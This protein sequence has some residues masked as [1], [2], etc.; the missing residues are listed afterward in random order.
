MSRPNIIVFFTDQQRFDSTG[1]HG[2]PMGLTP[3]FDRLASEGTFVRNSFTCQPVCG[4]ARACFQTGMY[5]TRTGVY[6]NDTIPRTDVR[7]LGH[8]FNDAGYDTAYIGKWHLGPNHTDK[9]PGVVEPQFRGGYKRW[10]ASNLLEFTSDAYQ[11]TL[12]DNDGQPVDLPG[13]RVDALADAAIRYVHERRDQEDPFFLFL[14]FLEPHHQNSRDDYPA[15]VGYASRYADAWVPPDLEA[16]GGTAPEHL[17]GYWGMVKR[18]DEA[19][20]R[21]VDSLISS[22]QIENTVLLFTSDHGNHFKTRNGEYKRS[23]HESSIRVPTMFTGGP[24]QHRGAL[25]EL[26][27]LIDLPATLLDVAGI[28]VPAEYDGHSILPLLGGDRESWQREVLIHVS[29]AQVGRALRT[30]RWKYGVTAPGKNGFQH[31]GSSEYVEESLYDLSVDP[32]ELCNLIHQAPHR[33]QADEL[34]ERLS[35]RLALAGEPN[36]T[37][38]RAAQPPA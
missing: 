1:L 36:V 5:Q 19:L 30:E 21:L 32:Y 23:C 10:L 20:G 26:V 38:H 22:R 37:I 7:Q 28:P 25:N 31:S 4:P 16:L 6:K 3:N 12:Y 14:S 15:P 24:F 29:E 11:T 2:N 27:S 33:A 8:R 34:R 35:R 18:L 13:Y 17:P 9:G